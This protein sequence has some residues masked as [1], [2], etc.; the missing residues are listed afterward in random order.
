[1]TARPSALLTLADYP[2]PLTGGKC[3][4]AWATVRALAAVTDLTVLVLNP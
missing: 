4:R 3:F 2:W 1:M